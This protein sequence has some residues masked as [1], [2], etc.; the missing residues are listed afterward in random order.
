[1]A[2]TGAGAADGFATGGRTAFGAGAGTFF[3][4][5]FALAL[6]LGRGAAARAG[7]RGFVREVGIVSPRVGTLGVLQLGEGGTSPG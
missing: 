1:L 2:A 3:G 6:G 5:V 4:G 7:R